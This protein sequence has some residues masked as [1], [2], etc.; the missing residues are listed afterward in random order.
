MVLNHYIF[1]RIQFL[2]QVSV[3]SLVWQNMCVEYYWISPVNLIF[4][5]HI[6]NNH[7]SFF[8]GV[9]WFHANYDGTQQATVTC[10][11]LKVL[12][13]LVTRNLRT[14]RYSFFYK[15]VS[16]GMKI[17]WNTSLCMCVVSVSEGSQKSLLLAF[18]CLLSLKL[19]RYM[20]ELIVRKT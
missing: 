7:T 17:C 19:Y 4:V 8:T 12:M 16:Q 11:S 10:C 15:V 5:S 3:R 2:M 18:C 14:Y 20:R 13:W 6:I 9:V 1:C